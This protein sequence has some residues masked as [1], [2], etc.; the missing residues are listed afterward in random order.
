MMRLLTFVYLVSSSIVP[1]Q[2]APL[3][4]HTPPTYVAQA[5]QSDVYVYGG[6]VKARGDLTLEVENGGQS[7]SFRLDEIKVPDEI[8][9]G[10]R[11]VVYYTPTMDAD[12]V[13]ATKVVVWPLW[14]RL[15]KTTTPR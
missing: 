1:A 4:G 6:R 10:V 14:K 2:G 8:K 3:P 9:P 7:R 5:D 11:V 13:Q 12:V 15:P